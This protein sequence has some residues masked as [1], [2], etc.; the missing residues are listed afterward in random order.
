MSTTEKN[1]K[2]SKC[3]KYFE[4]RIL[5]FKP[6]NVTVKINMPTTQLHLDRASTEKYMKLILDMEQAVKKELIRRGLNHDPMK[7]IVF[8][9]NLV[10]SWVDNLD[11]RHDLPIEH[12]AILLVN[13]YNNAYNEAKEDCEKA[14]YELKKNAIP[15]LKNWRVH[16]KYDMDNK[17]FELNMENLD[18]YF[19]KDP[20][21]AVLEKTNELLELLNKE[22]LKNEKNDI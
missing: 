3:N 8:R 19:S 11:I 14:L 5:K 18:K 17:L 22:K 12:Q 7:V 15:Y 6:G 2:V 21:D 1:F 16:D 13:W 10:A 4:T 9:L 20:L